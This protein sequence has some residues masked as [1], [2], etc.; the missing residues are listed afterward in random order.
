MYKLMYRVLNAAPNVFAFWGEKLED[1]T[2]VEYVFETEEEVKKG[3]R[4]LAKIVGTDDI[5]AVLD[6]DYYL[7]LI[8]GTIPTPVPETY[9]ITLTG[10]GTFTIEPEVLSNIPAGGSGSAALIFAEEPEAFHLIINGEEM[11]DGLPSW[12]DWSNNI[13]TFNNINQSYDIQI[14]LH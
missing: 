14:I 1:G 4:Q 3:G 11:K 13:L 6:E 9:E 12:I 10:D 8:Y 7:K 2:V 5:R